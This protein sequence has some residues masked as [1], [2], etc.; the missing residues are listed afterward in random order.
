MSYR[1]AICD[2]ESL[3]SNYLKSLVMAWSEEKELDCSVKTF[4]SAESLLFHGC[5]E[6]D[7]LLLD[8]EMAGMNGVEL[9][10]RVR[11]RDETSVIIFVT[12]YSEYI[13]EG[14][15]VQALNFLVKP[16][17]RA[18]LFSVLDKAARLLSKNE[19]SISLE[20]K[21]EV[22]LVPLREIRFIE[23]SGNYVSVHAKTTLTVKKTLAELEKLLDDRFVRTGR[24][25]IVNLTYVRRITKTD[26][27]LSTDECVPLS[28][29]MYEAINR[30]LIERM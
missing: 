29:G 17:D 23:V 21:G 16:I 4:S 8:I 28:R 24:S 12:G 22:Y 7:I 1:F 19:R 2:D 9:A 27:F 5:E 25:F 3:Q 13:A 26:V 10:K 15:D 11:E 6:F 14:Y 18:K 30:A 20:Q